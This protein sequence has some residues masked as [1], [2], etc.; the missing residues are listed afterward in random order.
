MDVRSEPTDE[1][2]LRGLSLE[3]FRGLRPRVDKDRLG[4]L[5][6]PQY[7]VIDTTRR[8]Q[9]LSADPENAVAVVL[10]EPNP[11]GYADAAARL[12]GWVDSGLYAVDPEPALYVYELRD[13]S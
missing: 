11:A 4:R 5:L 3:P 12:Q 13:G 6:C 1:T 9:L 2:A 10:P 8:S 7:D